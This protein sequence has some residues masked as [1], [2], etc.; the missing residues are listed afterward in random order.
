MK[1]VIAI[2]LG[3][4]C[5]IPVSSKASDYIINNNSIKISTEEY[6]NLIN[7]G[8]TEKE[9]F[10]MSA[11]EYENNKDLIGEIVSSDIKYYKTVTFYNDANEQ[12]AKNDIEI[13]EDE[14]SFANSNT[15]SSHGLIVGYTETNYKKMTTNIISLSN[16]YRYKVS[17]EWKNMP[18]TRSYDIIGIGI[19][20]SVYIYSNIYFQQ[21]YCYND[22]SCSSSVI[23]TPKKTNTGGAASFKL[24]TSSSISD[25]SSYLYFTVDKSSDNT[26][27]ELNAYGDY[28]H[29][30][31]SI[32][33]E[34]A[35]NYSINSAGIVLNSSIYNKYDEIQLAHA[36]WT[37]SW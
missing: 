19:D 25:L 15:M 21:N 29:A 22:G 10:N 23:S 28:S 30:T 9:I 1:K 11:V 33:S 6:N 12:V 26:L 36:R 27:S 34:S 32:D 18:S 7:L 37:G 35:K 13:S 2:I 4:I 17:L 31:S 3:I 24:P 20:S 5:L 8:F 16:K 14:Y